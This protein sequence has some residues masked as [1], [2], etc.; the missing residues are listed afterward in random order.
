MPD[1]KRTRREFLATGATTAAIVTSIQPARA[2]AFTPDERAALAAAMDEIIPAADGMPAASQVGGVDY[3]ERVV[4]SVE[5]LLDQFRRGLAGLDAQ[6]R[7]SA[8]QPFA[9]LPRAGRVEVLSA[10]ERDS[11]FFRVL[12]DFTYEAYYTRPE[13]WK[14]IGYESHLTADAGPHMKPFDESTLAQVRK[15]GK[16]YREVS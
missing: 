9:Q 6:S 8:S 10:I 4:P 14:S 7:K 15:R 11:D 5:G 2:A 16:L 13:V 12:R 1:R 3:L